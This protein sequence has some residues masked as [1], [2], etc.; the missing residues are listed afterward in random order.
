[1]TN[2]QLGLAIKELSR[3]V[4]LTIPETN[5]DKFLMLLISLAEEFNIEYN[6]F[7]KVDG[8]SV[9]KAMLDIA[10]NLNKSVE[11]ITLEDIQTVNDEF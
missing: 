9:G 5:R 6:V 8:I 4:V 10:H 3:Y 11:D 7:Y 1:M 2:A